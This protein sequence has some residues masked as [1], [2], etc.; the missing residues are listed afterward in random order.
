MSELQVRSSSALTN[1]ADILAARAAMMKQNIRSN[2]PTL[3]YTRA[4]LIKTPDGREVEELQC[5]VLDFVYRNQWYAKPFSKGEF[6]AVSCQAVGDNSNE[7]LVPQDNVPDRQSTSCGPCPKN[8]W[9]SAP[10]GGNGKACSNQMLLAIM[11][12][13]LSGDDDAIW[14]AK[15]QPTALANVGQHI[16]KMIDLYG[17]PAKVITTLRCDP[18]R[19]Y[20][21]VQ[22]AFQAMNPLWEKHA[23]HLEE[24]RRAL[25]AGAPQVSSDGELP[26]PAVANVPE[27]LD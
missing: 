15:C 26:Q 27:V 17:H 16:A 18:A 1:P 13:D 20:P 23:L 7:F 5:V 2:A 4:G 9:G 21:S 8:Q 12:P 14:T 22:T 19:D 10:T 24:A 6:N 11:M 25:F 3:Q